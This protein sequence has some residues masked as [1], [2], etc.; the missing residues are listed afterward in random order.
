MTAQKPL[1]SSRRLQRAAGGA[2][3]ERQ[4]HVAGQPQLGPVAA[5]GDRFAQLA[6]APGRRLGAVA[7]A[8][9]A[10]HLHL[11][12]AVDAGH[13]PQQRVVGL[14][15]G[16]GPAALAVRGRPLGDRQRVVDDD[17][18][19]VGHPGRL[20]HQRARLVAAADRDDDAARRELEVAGAAV[21]QGAEG[22]GRVEAGQ[23]EPLDRAVV[24]DQGAG[25][26]VGEEAVAAD[27]REAVVG[28]HGAQAS[29]GGA[30]KAGAR[31][32]AESVT[33]R[34]PTSPA[35]SPRS[36]LLPLLDRRRRSTEAGRRPSPGTGRPVPLWRQVCFASGLLMIAIALF[37]PIG[38]IAEELVIAH[39]VEHLLLGDIATLLLVLG[40]TGPLLQPILAIRLFDRL[41]V[42]A[43][44]PSR[45]P[46]WALNFYFWHI[47]ALYDAAYGTAPLHALEHT[48]FIFFGCLMWMPIFGPLP[49]PRVVHRRLEGRL[50]DRRPLRRRD[51]R[52]RAD[53]VGHGAL[54]DLRAG[55]ALLGH[56]AARRPEHRRGDHDGRGDLPRPRRARLGLLRGRPR[57][58]REAAPARPRPRARRRAR[59]RRAQRAVAAGHGDRL[60]QQLSPTGRL[61]RSRGGSGRH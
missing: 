34:S 22:A 35:S 19:G 61:R 14:V 8:R 33:F 25:V 31:R 49:K 36:R 6:A 16:V 28:G 29:S 23:A 39:M 32:Y 56:L 47:P 27:R 18:A 55:R 3:L 60:E 13:R 4:L 40:L 38:H 59:R 41:R 24:G 15:L 20:D 50:R 5:A 51:P 9:Q 37:S 42:L 54:P 57:G 53:V 1:S 46:L 44:P 11:D 45:F 26:A 7:E 21:E 2:V 12:L 48:T 10:L 43:H 30:A 52:Q 58:D 17:P